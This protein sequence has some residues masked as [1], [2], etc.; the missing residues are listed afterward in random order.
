MRGAGAKGEGE[1][2]QKRAMGS[3]SQNEA[4]PCSAGRGAPRHPRTPA[5]SAA[6][7][8]GP[9]RARPA[10]TPS[11]LWSRREKPRNAGWL[12]QCPL[13][14]RLHNQLQHPGTQPGWCTQM[15]GTAQLRV[16]VHNAYNLPVRGREVF[17]LPA[18]G[19]GTR[20]ARAHTHTRSLQA[21]AHADTHIL[22]PQ[23]LGCTPTCT[24]GTHGT[25][26]PKPCT[27]DLSVRA[28][29]RLR[30]QLA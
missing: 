1:R 20:C 11:G 9:G 28:Q 19:A 29:T 3:M 4:R 7:S 16:R 24:Q 5:L 17:H 18:R 6:P 8:R 23:P 10:N 12:R 26:W 30:S 25:S 13:P 21:H 15:A 27:R 22:T 2:K 14:P